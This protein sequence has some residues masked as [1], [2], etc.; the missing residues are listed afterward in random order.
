MLQVVYLTNMVQ[1]ES[2]TQIK[3]NP[4]SS[5]LPSG[6]YVLSSWALVV[7]ELLSFVEIFE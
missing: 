4:L 5:N 2:A 7:L 3:L 1:T 6:M